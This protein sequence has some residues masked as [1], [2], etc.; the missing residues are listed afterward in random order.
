MREEEKVELAKL[1]ERVPI[2]VKESLEEPSAKIN[3]LLQVGD[4]GGGGAFV[5]EVGGCFEFG[6]A[7]E[8]GGPARCC[9]RLLRLCRAVW[10]AACCALV[11]AVLFLRACDGARCAETDI[12]VALQLRLP[13][14]RNHLTNCPPPLSHMLHHCA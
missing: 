4:A 7:E 14:Q 9:P 1:V 12:P 3:V 13:C 8:G 10:A 2:P 6:F 5:W 11:H